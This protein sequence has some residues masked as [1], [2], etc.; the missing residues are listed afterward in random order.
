MTL[1]LDTTREMKV[2]EQTG[3]IEAV[4]IIAQHE[5]GQFVEATLY[6]DTRKDN[7][8]SHIDDTDIGQYED[9]DA[10]IEAKA[11]AQ[12]RW[13]VGIVHNPLSV[14]YR[15]LVKAA[16]VGLDKFVWWTETIDVVGP[17]QIDDQPTNKDTGAGA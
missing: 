5:Q 12:G 1:Y 14:D 6:A 3:R 9:A 7:Y 17:D 15:E 16:D 11:G 8:L 4:P 10:Y 2:N 13:S